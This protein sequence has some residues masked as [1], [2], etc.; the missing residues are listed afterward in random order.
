MQTYKALVI[1]D[2]SA[3]RKN[4]VSMLKQYCPEI[5]VIG[6]ADSG[7]SGKKSIQELQPM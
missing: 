4:T 3:S 1:D 2:E 5:E 7:L 6:E